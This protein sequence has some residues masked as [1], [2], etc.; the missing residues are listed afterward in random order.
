MTAEKQRKTFL[1]Y[2]RVNKDFAIRLAKELKSEGFNIWLDQ[3]DIPAGARWD[4]EV[5]KALR[6]SEI[7]MIILTSASVDS[8][9]VMDEIGY[10]I[11][12]NKRFLPVL[13]EKCEVPFRLRRFQYVDFTDKSFDDGVESAKE[14]LRGLVAQPTIPRAEFTASQVAEAARKAKEED[15]RFATQK[16]E[17]E[18][19][20]QQKTDEEHTAKARAEKERKAK[21]EAVRL[22]AQKAKVER[23]AQE[24]VETEH[25]KKLKTEADDKEKSTPSGPVVTG[26]KPAPFQKKSISGIMIGVGVGVIALI[27]IAAI[28][29]GIDGNLFSHSSSGQEPTATRVISQP[30]VVQPTRAVTSSKTPTPTKTPNLAMTKVFEGYNAEAQSFYKQG[31]LTTEN[32]SFIEHSA[33]SY[34]T[35]EYFEESD[36]ISSE[37]ISDF[38]ITAHFKWSIPTEE[39]EAAGCGIFFAGQQNG[40]MYLVFLE[41]SRIYFAYSK[42]SYYY[43]VGKTRGSG[44]VNFNSPAEADFTLIVNGYYAYVIV[45]GDLI[46]EYSLAKSYPVSGQLYLGVWGSD[47]GKNVSCDMTNVH[48]WIPQ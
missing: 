38:Y 18:R 11:D 40:D 28:R 41:D 10:A 9:N 14:L 20:A 7:F 22:A 48:V 24:K 26:A 15:D 25:L 32:G 37:N 6:E 34:K 43:E 30:V 31:Y 8:E 12:N 17:E 21:E 2:S 45:N 47:T 5:E 44:R 27:V 13:L 33:F 4:R 19:L 23:Q 1:S 35:T 29:L 36:I 46:G 42:G 39:K 16:A 3:M